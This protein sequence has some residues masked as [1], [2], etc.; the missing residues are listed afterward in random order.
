MSR[1]DALN[2]FINGRLP[3]AEIATETSYMASK[4]GLSEGDFRELLSVPNVP[5]ESYPQTP[6]SLKR[7]MQLA[8][9]VLR[10][11]RQ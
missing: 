11:V 4:L 7:G 2:E 6:Q 1:D 3:T 9:A 5:H 8:A 10:R